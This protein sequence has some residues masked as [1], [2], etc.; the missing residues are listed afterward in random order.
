MIEVFGHRFLIDISVHEACVVRIARQ[1][2]R[3]RTSGNN[4]SF[5]EEDNFIGQFNG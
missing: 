1:K 5:V 3:M 4:A 2:F